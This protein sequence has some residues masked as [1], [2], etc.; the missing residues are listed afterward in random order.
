MPARADYPA[1]GHV[2]L[3]YERDRRFAAGDIVPD[4]SHLKPGDILLFHIG[5]AYSHP[6]TFYQLVCGYHRPLAGYKHAGILLKDDRM[7]HAVPEFSPIGMTGV[8]VTP[9]FD[10]WQ[11]QQLTVLRAS[12]LSRGKLMDAALNAASMH[13]LRYGYQDIGFAV[14]H[15]LRQKPNTS[16]QEID[17]LVTEQRAGQPVEALPTSSS[18]VRLVLSAY[19]RVDPAQ[20]RGARPSPVPVPADLATNANL[21]DVQMPYIQL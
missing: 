10:Y 1:S 17:D 18:C 4:I 14:R 8:R 2:K 6:V 16:Q 12:K 15:M 7:V 21:Q 5:N 9:L 3:L 13:G 19:N 11:A 20:L